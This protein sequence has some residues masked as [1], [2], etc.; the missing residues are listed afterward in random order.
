VNN[1]EELKIWIK[2][3]LGYPK[4]AIELTDNQLD[5]CISYAFD[6]VKSSIG[7]VIKRCTIDLIQGQNEYDIPDDMVGIS[8][9]YFYSDTESLTN[10]LSWTGEKGF[11]SPPIGHLS[12]GYN[13][14][15]EQ[16]REMITRMFGYDPSYSIIDSKFTLEPAPVTSG[17][18]IVEYYSSSVTF[19]GLSTSRRLFLQEWALAEAKEI[20]GRI[21]SKFESVSLP[22]GDRRLDGDT[23]LAEAK[24]TKEKLETSASQRFMNWIIG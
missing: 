13:F 14:Q 18:C 20:L 8:E 7:S 21:R 6:K 2:Q 9:V 12:L 4:I 3:K 22:G 15:I 5:Q 10:P 17:P 1:A 24:E 23:L 11:T 19:K 16:Q